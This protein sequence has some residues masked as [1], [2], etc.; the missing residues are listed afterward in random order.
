[1]TIN[2]EFAKNKTASATSGGVLTSGAQTIAGVKT[3]QDN[4]LISNA[5]PS[6]TGTQD[7]TQWIKPLLPL[8]IKNANA[9]AYVA[10]Y[11]VGTQ[12][13][14]VRQTKQL[15]LTATSAQAGWSVAR[16]LG[17]FYCDSNGVW[18]INFTIAGTFNSAAITS[19]NVSITGVTFKNVANNYT[20]ITA[21]LGT[22]TAARAFILP[23][24]GT[25]SADG[26]SVTTTLIIFSGDA[27]LVDAEPTTYTTQAN[28]E[29]GNT[30]TTSAYYGA[31][32]S[33]LQNRIYLTPY[34]L[35]GVSTWQYI[36][37]SN[38]SVVAYTHGATVAGSYIGAV[39]SPT[40]NRIYFIPGI[41]YAQ[42]IWH[43]VDCATGSVVAYA[44]GATVANTYSGG[45]YSPTQNRIYMCP[46]QQSTATVWHYIDCST[47]SV[48]AYNHGATVVSQAYYGGGYSPT[49]N[50]IYLSP[51]VQSS[52]TVWHYVDCATGSVV[53]YTHGATMAINAYIAA[54][55][56]P[57]QNRLYFLPYAQGT[58]TVWHYIDC[59]NGS[60]V[61]YTH[62]ATVGGNGYA[63]GCYSPTQ[64]R[65]YLS[66]LTQSTATQWHY[67][68]CNTGSVV[69]YSHNLS[70][71]PAQAYVGAVY[72][73]TQ[74]RI[75]LPPYAQATYSSWHYITDTGDTQ[76][77]TRHMFGSTI[78]SSTY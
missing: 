38:G 2:L 14:T 65:I 35:V 10:A 64:N 57:T 63:G 11:P 52:A 30:A 45:V 61:A 68:D 60:L 44:H 29:G 25:M 56:S 23:N 73:P 54:S 70:G 3:F 31:A 51:L 15:A 12:P 71:V 47:G 16:A 13:G 37:C 55:Y 66:P 17:R 76:G 48:V 9:R 58:A 41:Q 40:Q 32:Y 36:D 59:S 5:M 43:Y 53:A 21:T 27:E 74:N 33:P 62:G 20:S 1:M 8:H 75:Y 22:T 69:A 49:Q 72:S 78:L 28:M 4:M 18:K 46:Y 34:N 77:I 7:V 39:Y 42:P 67:I 19:I 26:F 50:R 24:T 6:L